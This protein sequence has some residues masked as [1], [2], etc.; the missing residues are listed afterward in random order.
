VSNVGRWPH[1]VGCY[2]AGCGTAAFVGQAGVSVGGGQTDVHAWRG[3]LEYGAD[4]LGC[5]FWFVWSVRQP[6]YERRGTHLGGR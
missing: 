1:R 2:V 5:V 3:V 6:R 4:T